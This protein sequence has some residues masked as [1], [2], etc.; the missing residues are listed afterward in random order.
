M[1]TFLLSSL[2]LILLSIVFRLYH[3]PGANLIMLISAVFFVV[4]AGINSFRKKKIW[5]INVLGGWLL[6]ICSIKLLFTY[7]YWYSGP[8]ILGTNALFIVLLTIMIIYVVVGLVNK[9]K[10]SKMV[11]LFSLLVAIFNFV[12]SYSICYF[13]DLNE[14]INKENN[15]TNY[16]SWDKYSWFLNLRGD[17]ERALIANQ[18]A[19]NAW[20]E[21]CRLYHVSDQEYAS[22]HAI[23][24]RHKI[25]IID[26]SW[27]DSYLR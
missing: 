7:L 6:A 8:I 2:S 24:K 20:E 21:T 19:V 25:G 22:I 14:V 16:S 1:K 9:N 17:K 4:F 11:L 5:N 23:L 3:L 27:D 12:P 13:F 10:L 15:S 26:N 18:K